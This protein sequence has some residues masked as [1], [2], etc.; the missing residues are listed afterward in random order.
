M[1]KPNLPAQAET[2]DSS[3]TQAMEATGLGEVADALPGTTEKAT[4]KTFES[5]DAGT[6]LDKFAEGAGTALAM[7]FRNPFIQTIAYTG[8][9]YIILEVGVYILMNSP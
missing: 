3:L 9:Q 7:Q 8:S 2:Q 6:V 1:E 4:D 5:L